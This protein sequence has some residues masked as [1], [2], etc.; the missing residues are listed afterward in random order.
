VVPTELETRSQRYAVRGAYRRKVD[1]TTTLTL[2]L[3]GLVT[4]TEVKRA[5]SITLPAREGDITVFGQPPGAQVNADDWSINELGVAPFAVAQIK[6]GRLELQPGVRV[7]PMVVDG[8]RALPLVGSAPQQGFRRIDWE[9]DPRVAITYKASE[10]LSLRTGAGLYHQP[11]DPEDLS[12]VF[13][14]PT[15]A[16]SSAVHG[17]IG[18]AY[19]LRST[20]TLELT[21]FAK[22]LWD[23][24]ARSELATPALAQALDQDGVGR[25]YGGQ[26]LLRQELVKGFFGW[27]T[28]SLIR[29]ERKDHPDRDWRL[30]DYDQTHVLGVLAS[31]Q[32]GHGFEIGGRFRFTSGVPRTPVVDKYFDARSDQFDPLFGAQNSIRVPSFYQLDL[33]AERTITRPTWRLN[34]F[35]DVQNVTNRANPEEI[36][37][38]FDFSRRGY[39]TGLPTLAVV[40][41]RLEI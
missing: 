3:D 18:G 7:E 10:R 35:V 21:G 2:G 32:L 28:Y 27:I 4:H 29:S 22:Y 31:Y 13:G 34:V 19:K 16:P 25:S 36:I 1:P 38:N 41:A 39:I 20:L 8:S 23:L 26:L 37:Y 6:T 5:G 15:L 17:V 33:R 11:P 24:P 14:N 30:F 9:L 40:G 12:S